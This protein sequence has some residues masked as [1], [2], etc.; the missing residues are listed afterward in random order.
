MGHQLAF[1]NGATLKKLRELRSVSPEFLCRRA[2]IRSDQLLAWERCSDSDYPTMRQ[3]EKIAKILLSPLAG[4]YLDPDNLPREE[5]P[6]VVNKRRMQNACS[7]DDSAYHLA[8]CRLAQIRSDAIEIAAEIGAPV[9]RFSMS[10]LKSDC[11]NA[12]SSIR[13]WIGFTSKDQE[14]T[15]SSRKLFL[16]LRAKFERHGILVVQFGGIAT[17]ELRGI[18]LYYDKFPVIGINANDR[19]PAKTFSL[20][21]ELVHLSRGDSTWCNLINMEAD[22]EEEVFCNAVAGEFLFSRACASKEVAVGLKPNNLESIEKTANR[23]SISRDVVAR[24]LYDCGYLKK[25]IYERYLELFLA[26]IE[27]KKEEE[28]KAREAGEKRSWCAPPQ[29]RMIADSF[30]SLYCSLVAQGLANG[31][32]S[33]RDACDSFGVGV[34]K[35]G[36]VFEEAMF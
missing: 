27:R 15:A 30:G 14:K 22:D 17:E 12:A 3:A 10:R 9:Q 25:E 19:W 6:R 7:F 2:N 29:E 4:L 8:V 24:R 36:R 28:R 11:V 32:L 33:E 23:Y 31:L 16:A 18:A 34:E 21:H 13:A 26:D 20:L 1:I 35:L 5:I